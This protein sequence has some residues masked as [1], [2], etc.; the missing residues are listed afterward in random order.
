V[1]TPT[2]GGILMRRSR[3]SV[4]HRVVQAILLFLVALLTVGI[5]SVMPRAAT[6]DPAP[7]RHADGP[8]IA[9]STVPLAA[10]PLHTDVPATSTPTPPPPATQP[11]ITPTPTPHPVSVGVT[12][13]TPIATAPHTTTNTAISTASTATHSATDVPIATAVAVPYAVSPQNHPRAAM[14]PPGTIIPGTI[15]PLP[16][17]HPDGTIPPMSSITPITRTDVARGIQYTSWWNGEYSSGESDLTLA[18]KIAPLGVNW[19]APIVTGYSQTTTST[20]IDRTSQRTPTDADLTH[21]VVTAHAQGIKVML[22]P[23]VDLDDPNHWRGEINMNSDVEWGLWFSNYTAFITHYA[24]LA[25]I[26]HADMFAVGTELQ[27]AS[28]RAAQWRQVVA[29]VRAVY[30]GPITYASNH[31][32]EVSVTW[33]DAL[34]IIG[35]DAYYPLTTIATPTVP[36]LKAAWAPA[37]AVLATLSA[38][39]QKPVVFTEVGYQSQAGANITPW[40][41]TSNV[42]DPQEQANCYTALLEVFRDVPW[43]HGVFW[44]SAT[45]YRN[46]GGPTDMD[47]TPI[48]KPAGEV[49]RNYYGGVGTSGVVGTPLPAPGRHPDATRTP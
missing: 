5:T 27:G 48:N 15:S 36:Q 17:R 26:T 2:H 21:L 3:F 28:G 12:T 43:W 46:Q 9:A 30:S 31:G 33:W 47:F 39:Y 41:V 35:V 16:S 13:A 44:W 40:S 49:L 29:A 37:V 42:L 8:V 45:P 25:Q 11:T 20:G 10:M 38:T 18:Q 32:E 19:L 34:D 7:A 1:A 4:F 6:P 23:H 14:H 24:A 22:K